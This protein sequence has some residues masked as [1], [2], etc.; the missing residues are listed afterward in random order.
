MGPRDLRSQTLPIIG[1]IQAF[2][3]KTFRPTA[4]AIIPARATPTR[5]VSTTMNGTGRSSSSTPTASAI[6]RARWI[7]PSASPRPRKLA[8][9]TRAIA[10][11]GDRIVLCGD[12]NVEPDSRTFAILAEAGLADLVTGRG[13]AGTR[14]S[15][16]RKPARFAD[17]MLVNDLVEVRRFEVVTEPEVS[18]HCPLLLEV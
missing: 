10:E 12:F 18:D 3:H 17:Y 16:Y 9:L 13:H 14:T 4:T 7:R 15:Y 5:S 6:S 8:D 1:Q 11:A 2:V